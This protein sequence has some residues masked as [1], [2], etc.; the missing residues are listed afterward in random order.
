MRGNG[1]RRRWP[2]GFELILSFFLCPFCDWLCRQSLLREV[3]HSILTHSKVDT[4]PRFPIANYIEWPAVLPPVTPFCSPIPHPPD[5]SPALLCNYLLASPRSKRSNC[6]RYSRPSVI[7]NNTL[8]RSYP[9]DFSD[10][11]KLKPARW[12]CQD[13]NKSNEPKF[14]SSRVKNSLGKSYPIY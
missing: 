2:F 12:R 14:N 3:I 9:G 11:S 10:K 6:L 7:L 13:R 4:Y 1:S 8:A 5:P